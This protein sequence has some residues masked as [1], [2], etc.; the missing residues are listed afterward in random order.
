MKR[1]FVIFPLGGPI[2]GVKIISKQIIDRFLKT[3]SLQVK[4]IDVAQ[5][6]SFEDFGKFGVG[7]I[8]F[9]KQIVKKTE[10][11]KKEDFVYMN[12][13][14][15]GFAFYRDYYIL[16]KVLSKS[17]NV[18]L[19]IHA[20][21]L[22]KKKRFFSSAKFKD[23]KC[24]F[25][26]Q[27]QYNKIDF[28]EKKYLL[29]N[30]LEDY[31]NGNFVNERKRETIKI[32]FFSNLSKPKGVQSLYEFCEFCT[33]NNKDFDITICGG[34]LDSFSEEKIELIRKLDNDRT[35]ILPP[36]T[37]EEQKMKLFGQTDFLLLLS[38]AYYEVYPLVYIE[39]LMNGVSVITTK[40]YVSDE[41]ISGG[42]GSLFD[43]EQAVAF[44]EKKK[45]KLDDLCL[46]NR[47]KFEKSYNFADY[48]STIKKY[49]LND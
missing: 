12:F 34:I 18:T 27:E 15:K 31:Y 20:N 46:A 44:I 49:I 24:I 21:G 23:V 11:I 10:A 29:P 40:Q 41:I 35:T 28:F 6:K 5:A 4:T 30:A 7:K 38:D 33:K 1:L 2:N 16:S 42:T 45:D 26:T 9:L 36:V 8:F 32:L 17:K 48:F 37:D 22:E 19:H 47:T 43:I 3:D 39:A 13:S 14:T 25:I